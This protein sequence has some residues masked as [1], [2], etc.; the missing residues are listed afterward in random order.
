MSTRRGRADERQRARL[1]GDE[2]RKAGQRHQATHITLTSA[3][4]PSAAA[5][6]VM[7]IFHP[8]VMSVEHQRAHCNGI[9]GYVYGVTFYHTR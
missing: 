4:G 7:F 3:Y 2:L 5:A 1:P 8:D 6:G 9:F